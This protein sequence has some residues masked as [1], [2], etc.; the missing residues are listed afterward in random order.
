MLIKYWLQKT[1]HF[2]IHQELTN[3]SRASLHPPLL[4]SPCYHSITCQHY[5][6]SLNPLKSEHYHALSC[7]WPTSE[8][9][10]K[11][12]CFILRCIVLRS[13]QQGIES[14]NSHPYP[15]HHYPHPQQ[16]STLWRNPTAFYLTRF[17]LVMNLCTNLHLHISWT[18]NFRF[19]S[20]KTAFGNIPW[21]LRAACGTHLLCCRTEWRIIHYRQKFSR[22]VFW[23]SICNKT[24][25]QMN[26][27]LPNWH[28]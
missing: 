20:I 19:W 25:G 24:R 9:V 1:C 4:F 16:S 5:Y 26:L 7:L 22:Q 23:I 13:L 8:F 17:R 27:H 10:S 15:H 12:I 6:S 3:Y 18:I 2:L 14:Q 28:L 21:S 11:S